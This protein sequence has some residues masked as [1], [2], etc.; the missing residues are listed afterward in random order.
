[1]NLLLAIVARAI[2]S[3]GFDRTGGTLW[4]QL[5]AD[6]EIEMPKSVP[7]FHRAQGLL[8]R[9]VGEECGGVAVPDSAG[10]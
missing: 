6:G 10:G 5:L 8:L 2:E 1:M 4:T 7:A 3:G 9:G